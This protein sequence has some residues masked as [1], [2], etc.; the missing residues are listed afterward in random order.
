MQSLFTSGNALLNYKLYF[1]NDNSQNT[2]EFVVLIHGLGMDSRL[3]YKIIPLLKDN[4]NVV[5]FDLRAHGLS[6]EGNDEISWNL[7]VNDLTNLL[8]EL[9]IKTCHF[10]GHGFG[11]NLGLQFA[12]KYPDTLKTLT[13]IT[14]LIYYPPKLANDVLNYRKHLSELGSLNS[15]ADHLIPKIITNHKESHDTE[16]LYSS[17]AKVSVDKYFQYFNLLISNNL[18]LEK[19]SKILTP[20]LIIDGE[21]DS[22]LPKKLTGLSVYSLPN[23]HYT[24]IQN[25]ANATFLDQPDSTVEAIKGFIIEDKRNTFLYNSLYLEEI[26]F[27]I[28]QILQK[29]TLSAKTPK[30]KVQLMNTF[31]VELGEEAILEGW[32]QRYAKKLLVYLIFH[33]TVVREQVCDELFREMD[34]TN[35]K[36]N[37]RIYLHHLRKLINKDNYEFVKSDKEHI[38][39]NGIVECD[40]VQYISE[41]DNL[42]NKEVSLHVKEYS[43]VVRNTPKLIFPG[44]FDNWALKVK[45]EIQLKLIKLTK[46]L[47]LFF[48]E[49]NEFKRAVDYLEFVIYFE[50]VESH[51]YELIILLYRK[52]GNQEKIDYWENKYKDD[53]L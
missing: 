41:I 19:I 15:I 30:L 3:W 8:E 37:L 49:Q 10:I 47:V 53:F 45:N 14:S 23:T 18:E 36:K 51:L 28:N 22:I 40:L 1:H 42:L 33:R 13:M 52:L 21:F 50:N 9:D 35:A 7:L 20:T 38:F 29:E 5:T 46:D 44:I 25:A 24:T 34:L 39:L 27:Q 16:I 43:L 26:G 31:H 17:Y 11:G 4:F 32:N 6:S 2:N 12:Y 48:I